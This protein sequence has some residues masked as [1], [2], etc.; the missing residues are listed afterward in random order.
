MNASARSTR[1]PLAV[2]ILSMIDCCHTY[3]KL[4]YVTTAS[5]STSA[6]KNPVVVLRVVA[7]LKEA[8]IVESTQG[9]RGGLRLARKA[10]DITLCDVYE[11]V[12]HSE[13]FSLHEANAECP[14]A[15][16]T[17]NML[18]KVFD[19]AEADIRARLRAVSIRDLRN[20]AEQTP[21]FLEHGAEGIGEILA[22]L[23]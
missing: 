10:E 11:A 12:E 15:R 7:M 1:F 3:A 20:E 16:V 23:Q 8:G 14:V 22:G 9:S 17:A 21:E 18:S 6:A 4:D 2:N 13:T 5:I 19:E